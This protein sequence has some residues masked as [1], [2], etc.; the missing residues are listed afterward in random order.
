MFKYLCVNVDFGLIAQYLIQNSID[1]YLK[2]ILKN[3]RFLYV[4]QLRLP[5]KIKNQSPLM[6]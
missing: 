4:K 1:N 3:I 6:T 2:F 5:I